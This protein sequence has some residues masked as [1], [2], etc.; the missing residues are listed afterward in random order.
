MSS[1]DQL[2]K[3][4]N[5][6][7]KLINKQA[8][9]KFIRRSAKVWSF[10]GFGKCVDFLVYVE[11]NRSCLL[12]ECVS[13]CV[14]HDISVNTFH[15]YCMDVRKTVYLF[16]DMI[17]EE[18]NEVGALHSTNPDK[19]TE[20]NRILGILNVENDEVK[21]SIE[22]LQVLVNKSKDQ[23]FVG[24]SEDGDNSKGKV[25]KE[26]TETLNVGVSEDNIANNGNKKKEHSEFVPE[27]LIKSKDDPK[28]S[29][30]RPA[31]N[32]TSCRNQNDER[33][34]LNIT[35]VSDEQLELEKRQ[36]EKQK[37]EDRVRFEV[38]KREAEMQ[39]KFND[40]LKEKNDVIIKRCQGIL[41]LDEEHR[42]DA[43]TL[44]GELLIDILKEK[45]QLQ[46]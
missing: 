20:I 2:V 22:E 8:C 46:S 31:S 36:E 32:T 26:S 38:S 27:N 12:S 7:K 15:Q 41:T 4:I 1:L 9:L 43:T 33:V 25:D 23:D 14:K 6:D 11:K 40:F 5:S 24:S 16:R 18:L 39:M 35:I 42:K 44:A 17:Y 13:I 45:G 30:A 3:C 10:F 21:K 37:F 29:T 19:N 28:D 34:R